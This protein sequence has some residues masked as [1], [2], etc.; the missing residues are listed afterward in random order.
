MKAFYWTAGTAFALVGGWVLMAPS[1]GREAGESRFGTAPASSVVEPS[2][3]AA[4]EMVAPGSQGPN[5]AVTPTVGDVTLSIEPPSGKGPHRVTAI[6][7]LPD[8]T[9][10]MFTVASKSRPGETYQDTAVVTGGKAEAGPFG[11]EGKLPPGEYDVE[12]TMPIPDVQSPETR[13]VIGD[14][15]EN[16]RGPLVKRGD[17]GVTVEKTEAFTLGSGSTPNAA[18]AVLKAK[19]LLAEVTA[20]EKATH[21]MAL[22][23]Q[24]RDTATLRRCGELM[25]KHQ[26]EAERL[27]A[28]A[29]N[30][31]LPLGMHIGIAAGHLV[32]CGSCIDTA[33]EDC[34]R[35]R[36][37][38]KEAS[39][40]IAGAR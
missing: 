18:Q 39:E 37:S 21:A 38:I 30:L 8:G 17:M 35:A 24:S 27:R 9:S 6:T 26:P 25:R 36:G 31:P 13:R 22:L 11:K 2:S 4:P 1:V 40:A 5:G 34:A 23:R 12:V 3:R 7:S 29:S 28:Q 20:L 19:E 10:L 16:L 14:K 33:E 15:G 32:L